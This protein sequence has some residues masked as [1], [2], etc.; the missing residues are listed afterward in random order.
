VGSAYVPLRG[1]ENVALGGGLSPRENR[2]RLR[3][4]VG[5]L[6]PRHPDISGNC[7]EESGMEGV[8]GPS[9]TSLGSKDGAFGLA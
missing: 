7:K 3:L 6:T 4:K 1:W 2:L 9:K 5:S 8:H